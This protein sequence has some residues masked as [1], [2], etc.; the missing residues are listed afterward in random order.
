MPHITQL[1]SVSLIAL[2]LAAP[3]QAKTNSDEEVQALIEELG[4][5]ES[6]QAISTSPNW[7]KPERI[8]VVLPSD[9]RATA[10][11]MLEQL[12]AV[13]HGTQLVPVESFDALPEVLNGADALLGLCTPEVLQVGTHLRWIQ[14]YSAGVDRCVGASELQKK[15]LLLTNMQRVHGPAIAE[16]VLATLLSL[17]R[18]LPEYQNLQRQGIWGKGRQ[19]SNNV[20]EIKGKTILIVGLGGIGTEIAKRV[21]ALGM[22]VIATRNSRREGPAYVDYVGLADELLE[23]S[24]QADVVVNATPLTPITTGLFNAP[25]FNAMRPTAFF[26]NIGRGKSVVTDDLI[27]ALKN[28]DIAAAGLDVTDP[29]PLPK[30]SELWRLPNVLITPHI[31]ARSDQR[32]H[33]VWLLVQEN[34]RRYVRGE[35]M[36][37]VVD[38]KRGY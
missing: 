23:L 8:V 7:Q 3:L 15:D 17:A 5:R 24:K 30:D 22:R 18:G 14:T 19:S 32:M 38:I 20:I 12:Q 31:S 25:I 1:L 34:L 9:H 35:R 37:N 13:S 2:C 33:R 29:E 4:L 11:Q 27:H 36:L 21:H 6:P 10:S 26:I 16:H 28:G